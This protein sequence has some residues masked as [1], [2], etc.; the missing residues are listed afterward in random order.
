MAAAADLT[1]QLDAL[2]LTAAAP[3]EHPLT[4]AAS[5]WVAAEHL[6]AAAEAAR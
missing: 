5:R 4:G 6:A 3:V 1:A 2:V